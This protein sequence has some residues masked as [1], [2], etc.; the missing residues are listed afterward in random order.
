MKP[1]FPR[2][3]RQVDV[4]TQH[5][6]WGNPLAV[7]LD[8]T[9]LSDADMQ[10][11]ASW[12]H[13]SETTFVFS[14]SP[15]GLAAGA[16]YRVRIFTPAGELPFAGHPTLGTCHAWLEAGGQPRQGNVIVQ[17]CA[18]G[19]VHLK[20][21]EERLSFAAPALRRTEPD[22]GLVTEVI[23]ALG[24]PKN[25]VLRTQMLDNGPAWLGLWVDCAETLLSL[26]PDHRA[27]LHLN[28]KVGLIAMHD[29]PETTPLISRSNREARAF[30]RTSASAPPPVT[31]EVRAFAAPAGIDEDPATGSLNASLAQ[32]LMDEGHLPGHYIA[33]QGTCLGRNGQIYLQRDAAGQVWVGGDTVTC[34]QGEVLL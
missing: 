13:L 9:D 16:D 29:A 2:A 20:R 12:T 14:P 18:A 11:F 23:A 28:T 25:H 7:V 21:E 1:N 31:V 33:T 30:S 5:A 17:E 26:T 24:L 34:V 19:L 27:L 4:F 3:F 8:G 32:W 6:Y 15:Q 10:R 22:A